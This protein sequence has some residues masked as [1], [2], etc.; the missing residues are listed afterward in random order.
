MYL[1]GCV[2]LFF[3]SFGSGVDGRLYT[4]YG[5]RLSPLRRIDLPPVALALVGYQRGLVRVWREFSNGIAWIR[6]FADGQL[7]VRVRGDDWIRGIQPHL[8]NGDWSPFF[9]PTAKI[10]FLHPDRAMQLSLISVDDELYRRVLQDLQVAF[11]VEYPIP[12]Y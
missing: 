7:D 11:P 12:H 9:A 5:T 4:K 2:S 3:F 8:A 6:L 1:R 10:G